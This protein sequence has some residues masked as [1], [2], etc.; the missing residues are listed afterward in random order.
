MLVNILLPQFFLPRESV[1]LGRFIISKE[2]PHQEYHDPIL[3]ETVEPLTKLQQN[4]GAYHLD[5]ANAGL[6]SALTSILSSAISKRAKTSVRISTDLVKTYALANS[7]SWFNEAIGQ[8]ATQKW[9]ERAVNQ[10][11]DIYVIVG[12]HTV[13][14]TR[15]HQEH[16]HERQI[17]SQVEV[18]VGLSLATIGAIAPLGN[19]TDPS[20]PGHHQSFEGDKSSFLAPGEQVSALQVRKV[21]HRFLSSR[22]SDSLYLS[23]KP[24]WKV[25]DRFR[26]E[27]E[28]VD[29]FIETGILDLE[30]PEDPAGGWEKYDGPEGEVFLMRL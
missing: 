14:D 17:T 21:H 6:A 5:A 8:E 25:F 12:F 7:D 11:D 29:D 27:E 15:I 20:I 22:N 3:A 30:D 1:K 10:G 18:P 9:V 13:S 19:I 2:H 24:K 4:Y 16:A 23:K 26:D 28:E